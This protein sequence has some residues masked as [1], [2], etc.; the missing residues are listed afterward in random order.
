MP[1]QLSAAEVSMSHN[2]EMEELHFDYQ[3]NRAEQHA[4]K[5]IEALSN[6]LIVHSES[7]GATLVNFTYSSTYFT[8]IIKQD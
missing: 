4:W 5:Y 8:P 3:K 6:A 2:D 1:K 7:P